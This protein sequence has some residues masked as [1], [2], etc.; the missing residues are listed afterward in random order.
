MMAN[1]G[2]GRPEISVVIP[3]CD[4]RE[5]LA[6]SLPLTVAALAADAVAY[7]LVIVDNDSSDGTADWLAVQYPAARIVALPRNAGFGAACN[8]G[9]RAARGARILLLN[10]DMAIAPGFCGA[11]LPCFADPLVFAVDS[12][13]VDWSTGQPVEGARRFVDYGV[14]LTVRMDHDRAAPGPTAYAT[15]GGCVVDREKFLA[16]GGFADIFAPGYAEDFDASLCAWRRGWRVLHQPAALTRHK[17]QATAR[18]LLGEA[19][20]RRLLQR[21]LW[22]LHWRHLPPG[23]LLGHALAA[24]L[25]VAARTLRHGW[26]AL[27]GAYDALLR[28]PQALAGRP[29]GI[30]WRAVVRRVNGEQP[31]P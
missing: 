27:A 30:P 1:A 14:W 9:V 5:L 15:G 22:L 28:L 29:P 24:P 17:Q 13:M 31:G 3:V 18:R 25:I 8:R 10:D 12:R 21:N 26:P 19:G 6:E 16:L 2:S 20:R 11:L 7:E 23:W 4:S